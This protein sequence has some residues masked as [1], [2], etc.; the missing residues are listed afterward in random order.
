MDLFSKKNH[1]NTISNPFQ[2]L[3]SIQFVFICNYQPIRS[4]N[5]S[6]RSKL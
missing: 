3:R 5:K 1:Q 2:V 6:F 4:K